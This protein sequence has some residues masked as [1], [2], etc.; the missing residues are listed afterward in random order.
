MPAWAYR[1][2]LD[3][4]DITARVEHGSESMELTEN[5]SGLMDCTYRPASGTQDPDGPVFGTLTLEVSIAG[6]AYVLLFSGAVIRAT[7]DPKTRTYALRASTRIQEH[8]R[9]LGDHAAVDAALPG[10]LYSN[11]VFGDPPDDLWDYAELCMSS[12]EKAYWIGT[13]GNLASADWAAKG[14]AD[15]A[16]SAADVDSQGSFSYDRAD[17]ETLTNQVILELDYQT[18]RKKVRSHTV[19]WTG[20]HTNICD[21]L[22]AESPTYQWRMPWTTD[23]DVIGSAS[24]WNIPRG[25]QTDGPVPDG[26][27]S[28]ADDETDDQEENASYTYPWGGSTGNC[29]GG[30][31]AVIIWRSVGNSWPVWAAS[32]VGYVAM[33][34]QVIDRYQITVEAAAHIAAFGETVT[35]NRTGSHEVEATEWPPDAPDG[36]TA[37]GWAQ[38]TAG[39]YYED[40]EDETERAL[41]LDCAY[42]WACNQIRGGQR[43]N[44]LVCRAK[45][46]TDITLASSVSVSAYGVVSGPLKVR[47]IKYTM[48]PPRTELTLAVSRGQGGTTD[49]W[50]TP[51]RPDSTDPVTY[52]E[53]EEETD[54]PLSETT[55]I[56]PTYVGLLVDSD[57]A[58]DPDE[59]LGLVTNA[60]KGADYKYDGEEYE[61]HFAVEW[62]E[63]ESQASAG[64]ELDAISSWEIA[65]ANDSLTITA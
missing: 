31:E 51:A 19:S 40:D 20:P 18:Q 26:A 25:V 5:A 4:V 24:A 60:T 34:G 63:V 33:T 58:P 6:G 45:L 65:V 3:T 13:D 14:T 57:P 35:V 36:S 32:A 48:D 53:A 10:S 16:L 54:Y 27:G 44:N 62:P 17:A 59:R 39:D 12:T 22:K 56:L 15:V 49:T 43:A 23:V 8:F 37:T 1:I 41:M 47:T 52:W 50:A 46:R 38:D 21:W 61:F 42:A 9:A 2:K 55:T 30:G 11:A 28:V 7:W 64:V 29:P